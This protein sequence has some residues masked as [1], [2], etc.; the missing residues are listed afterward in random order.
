VIFLFSTVKTILIVRYIYYLH[1]IGWHNAITNA[2]EK[3]N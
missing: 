1:K 2:N 3:L